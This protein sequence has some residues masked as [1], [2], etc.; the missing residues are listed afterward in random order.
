MNWKTTLKKTLLGIPL[1]IA[2][3][4]TITLI[5]SLVVKDIPEHAPYFVSKTYFI[6]TYMASA[7]MGGIFGGAATIFDVDRWSLLKQTVIHFIISAVTMFAVASWTRWVSFDPQSTLIFSGIFL[8]VYALFFASQYIYYK[9][10][11]DGINAELDNQ[12]ESG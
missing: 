8:V 7:L 10:K 1:G 6:R 5:I 4:A 2:I 12:S 11:L 3:G 9:I